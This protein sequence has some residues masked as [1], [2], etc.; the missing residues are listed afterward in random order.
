MTYNHAHTNY[1][2][3]NN[4]MSEDIGGKKW[5]LPTHEMMH[6]TYTKKKK[7]IHFQMTEVEVATIFT[8]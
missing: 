1:Y 3:V 7:P 4:N 2:C 5:T 6:S 8:K